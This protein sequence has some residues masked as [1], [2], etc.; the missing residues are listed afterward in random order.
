MKR[1]QVIA[2]ILF[3]LLLT[4]SV[5]TVARAQGWEQAPAQLA[6][7]IAKAGVLVDGLLSHWVSGANL[8]SPD[9]E[10]LVA[11]LAHAAVYTVHFFAELATI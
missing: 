7:V 10:Q 1:W 6:A 2:A 5:A 8:T 11:A 9:G 4:F 3:P